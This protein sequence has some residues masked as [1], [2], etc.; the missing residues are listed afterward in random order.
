MQ[1][2]QFVPSFFV[3]RGKPEGLMEK[4]VILMEKPDPDKAQTLKS[5]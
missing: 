5:V 3:P 2:M 1:F 4:L